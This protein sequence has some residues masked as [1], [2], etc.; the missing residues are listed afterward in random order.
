MYLMSNR[1]TIRGTVTV[2]DPKGWPR[3]AVKT[4]AGDVVH[5]RALKGA[6]LGASVT[7]SAVC[8]GKAYQ[9]RLTA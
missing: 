2:I 7:F 5:V 6:E 4:E 8:C 3:I 9:A 1:E